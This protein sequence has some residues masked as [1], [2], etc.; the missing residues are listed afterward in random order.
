M[1]REGREF[2]ER[3]SPQFRPDKFID[4]VYRY[5]WHGHVGGSSRMV[6]VAC[7]VSVLPGQGLPEG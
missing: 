2:N 3:I 7:G 5:C 4:C 1:A 6:S